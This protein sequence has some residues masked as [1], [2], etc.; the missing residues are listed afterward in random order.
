M[1]GSAQ[2]R[3]QVLVV[4]VAQRGPEII[5]NPSSVTV[6]I[7][8]VLGDWP[9]YRGNSTKMDFD[10]D[11]I[12]AVFGHLRGGTIAALDVVPDQ[13]GKTWDWVPG[14]TN[15]RIRF[16]GVPS[17][18]FASQVG[19]DSPVTW[20]QGEAWP[21]KPIAIAEAA[22][23]EVPVTETAYG[24]QAVLGDAVITMDGDH[25]IAVSIPSDYTVTVHARADHGLL[26]GIVHP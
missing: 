16:N 23:G 26:L 11:R 21:V 18:R 15:K 9:L 17:A 7:D 12:G 2:S 4:N 19:T 8:V 13:N 24:R 5:E 3:D 22:K 1:S 10:P 20:K 6:I 25:S 14:Y